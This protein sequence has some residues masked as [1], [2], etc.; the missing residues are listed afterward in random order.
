MSKCSV[1]DRTVLNSVPAA[2]RV[3]RET[4]TRLHAKFS[5]AFTPQ[6]IDAVLGGC[7]SDLAGTPRYALPELSERLAQYR[8]L[9]AANNGADGTS[10]EWVRTGSRRCPFEGAL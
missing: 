10:V 6:V 3:C 1:L 4:T 7:L 5:G 8:L 2:C 9:D